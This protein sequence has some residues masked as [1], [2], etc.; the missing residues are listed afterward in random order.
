MK[1]GIGPD[2]H[3]WGKFKRRF[4]GDYVRRLHHYRFRALFL[5]L[6]HQQ[7][8]AGTFDH[9]GDIGRTVFLPE[10]D[11]V[12][13]P[14]AELSSM[15]DHVRPEQDAEFRGE[16]RR[17]ALAQ[18]IAAPTPAACG[19]MAPELG[20]AA[21]L[22]IDM[23]VDGLVT[24]RGGRALM[25]HAPGDLLGRPAGAQAALDLIRRPGSRPNLRRRVRRASQRLCATM[26]Q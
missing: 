5:V 16:F 17:R 13:F 8:A 10:E 6:Q 21:F 15:R 22:G 2:A 12:S 19:Q 1:F 4:R 26:H 14:M 9:R 23:V 20:P 3:I 11:Q 7:K 18:P 25:A 24:D